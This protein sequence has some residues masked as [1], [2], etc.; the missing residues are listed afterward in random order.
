MARV[1]PLLAPLL[2]TA[3]CQLR[4]TRAGAVLATHLELAGDSKSR[5]R[6]L[7]GRDRLDAGAALVI[8][9]CSSVHT[10]FMRFPIDVLFIRRDGTVVKCVSGLRP[11]RIALA[12]GAYAVVE[13][14]A[15]ALEQSATRRGD[16]V[17]FET[18]AARG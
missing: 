10:F 4:N 2:E 12:P 8:A 5:R 9:P 7:L 15:G 16:R 18:C 14:P 3:R 6:G 1:P 13:F 11:W 17:V